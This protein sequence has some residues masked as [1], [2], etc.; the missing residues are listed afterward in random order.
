MAAPG[1]DPDDVEV[2][3]TDEF[4]LVN[5]KT[6]AKTGKKNGNVLFS[7]F[8]R[9]NLFRRFVFPDAIDPDK[10]TATLA[11]GELTILAARKKPLEAAKD[12]KPKRV[13]VAA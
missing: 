6:A 1:F 11:K 10:V 3:A 13:A 7:D 8:G 12:A 4:V 5:A 9:R 2:K